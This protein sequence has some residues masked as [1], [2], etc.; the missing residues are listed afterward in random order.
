MTDSTAQ[1]GTW[2]YVFNVKR[3]IV[4][5][6]R[7][8][9]IMCDDDTLVEHLGKFLHRTASTIEIVFRDTNGLGDQCNKEHGSTVFTFN[10]PI[11]K[12]LWCKCWFWARKDIKFPILCLTTYTLN[13][14]VNKMTKIR[15]IFSYVSSSKLLSVSNPWSLCLSR[16]ILDLKMV[17]ALKCYHWLEHITFDTMRS[18]NHDSDNILATIMDALRGELSTEESCISVGKQVLWGDMSSVVWKEGNQ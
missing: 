5:S 15:L 16:C 9:Y 2:G 7:N 12:R 17:G 11:C 8:G 6:S 10:Y 3:W 1:Y 4:P 13:I 18:I 14:G